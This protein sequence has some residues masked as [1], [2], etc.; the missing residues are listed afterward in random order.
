MALTPEDVLETMDEKV[1]SEVQSIVKSIDEKLR[2]QFNVDSNRMAVSLNG[3]QSPKAEYVIE[4]YKA[5]GWSI[6]YDSY[7]GL[8]FTM[9][10]NKL[11]PFKD[12]IKRELINGV[13]KQTQK[14]TVSPAKP[15]EAAVDGSSRTL[16]L[17]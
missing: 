9:P 17:A 3:A 7:S 15:A 4:V 10:E 2:T 11:R 1:K 5:A 16:D 14:A 12:K 6:Q 13:T 8:I